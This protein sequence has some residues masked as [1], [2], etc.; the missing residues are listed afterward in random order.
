L[1]KMAGWEIYYATEPLN[2]KQTG[3]VVKIDL[4]LITLFD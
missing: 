3:T 4:P 1:N 2:N